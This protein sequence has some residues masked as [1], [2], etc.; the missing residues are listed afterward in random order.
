M[1]CVVIRCCMAKAVEVNVQIF[2]SHAE[3]SLFI[4][5]FF[6]DI[7]ILAMGSY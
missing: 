3:Y 6:V 5:F 1:V 4:Y 2:C 7:K